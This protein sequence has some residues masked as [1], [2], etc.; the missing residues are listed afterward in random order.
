MTASLPIQL[1]VGIGLVGFTGG[2]EGMPVLEG[3]P[4]SSMIASIRHATLNTQHST[5]NIEGNRGILGNLV[6]GG[7]RDLPL[8]WMLNVET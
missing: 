8:S 7:G 1:S 5:L 6:M 4:G 2:G 3:L